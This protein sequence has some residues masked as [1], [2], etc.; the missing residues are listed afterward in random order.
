MTYIT[1]TCHIHLNNLNLP[2][3]SNNSPFPPPPSI[4]QSTTK[5]PPPL[6]LIISNSSESDVDAVEV[7]VRAEDDVDGGHLVVG[8]KVSP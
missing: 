7:E 2:I 4:P 3:A 8:A 6:L 5:S 1:Q